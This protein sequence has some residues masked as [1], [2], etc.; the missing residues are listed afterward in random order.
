[1]LFDALY[2]QSEKFAHWIDRFPGKLIHL[3]AEPT[4]IGRVHPAD[5]SLVGDAAYG[6]RHGV[7]FHRQALHAWR[8]GL[9]HPVT[10]KSL[11]WE[12]PLPE[13]FAALLASLRR[14]G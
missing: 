12:S 6:R 14:V 8:L 1:M 10:R 7:P 2:G 3:D 13:D 5:V 9:V 11:Q 4:M